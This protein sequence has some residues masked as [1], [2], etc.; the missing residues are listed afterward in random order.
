MTGGGGVGI[1]IGNDPLPVYAQ[2]NPVGEDGAGYSGVRIVGADCPL[3]CAIKSLLLIATTGE[4]TRAR[5]TTILITTGHGFIG[6]STP[7][8]MLHLRTC[9][10]N[11]FEIKDLTYNKGHS[12]L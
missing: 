4:Q 5:I 2:I 11:R 3:Y 8:L 1:N 12:V 6:L 10:G 7:K 9:I